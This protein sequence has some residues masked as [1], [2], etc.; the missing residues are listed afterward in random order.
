ML[1]QL[2][3][4]GSPQNQAPNNPIIC[5]VLIFSDAFTDL[6]DCFDQVALFKFSESPVSVSVMPVPVE[7]FRLPTDLDR[8]PIK[9]MHIVKERQ[10]IIGVWVGR[11]QR[12]YSLKVLHSL[13][14]LFRFKVCE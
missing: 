2:K 3:F 8:V 5:A 11:L 13:G 1:C 7:F 9:L 4:A 10:V 12:Y 6:S 14:I